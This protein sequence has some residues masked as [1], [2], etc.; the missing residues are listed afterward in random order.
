MRRLID[1]A[2]VEIAAI[3]DLTDLETLT[4]L[5]KWD[6]VHGKLPFDASAAGNDLIVNGKT[7]KVF[8]E[9]DPAQLP[10]KDL[11]IDIVLECTGRFVTEEGATKHLEAGAKKVIL[12][13]PGKGNIKTV[14]IGVNEETLT[15]DERIVSNASCT[16]NCLAP[17]AK[18]LD[19]NFGIEKGYIS[20]VHAYT[21]DQQLQDAPHRDLRRAR[22]AALSIIPTSTG[23]AAAVGKVLPQLKGKLDGIALRVPVPDGS[24]TDFTVILK[25]NTTTEA[26]NAA[27]KNA[28]QNEMKGILEYSEE[29]LV[30]VDIVG[31]SHS[32]IFDSALTTVNDNLVK[33]VGWYD[34]EYGYACRTAELAL[35]LN[36]L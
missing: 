9:A 6:S 8:S 20:T 11:K 27:I 33:I 5:L 19:E 12:S 18:V 14:V 29:P 26:V 24:L 36:S 23:A 32:C 34:N 35:L 22:A 21:A 1:N 30:S 15:A 13:A 17:M 16:T 7:I 31:N 10:W 28:A 3:N 25:T 4:H 2:D